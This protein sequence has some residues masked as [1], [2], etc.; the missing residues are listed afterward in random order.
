MST[1]PGQDS[2][3]DAGL[4][5]PSLRDAAEVEP[6]P[7]ELDELGDAE[8]ADELREDEA[9]TDVAVVDPAADVVEEYRPGAPR[10]DLDDQANVA[11][12]TEQTREVPPDERDDYP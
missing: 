11:D 1:V 8:A 9:D 7:F 5:K 4:T 2:W 6:A 10:P 3:R 12:V